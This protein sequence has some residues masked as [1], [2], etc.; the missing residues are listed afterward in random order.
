MIVDGTFPDFGASI[1]RE[2]L[3]MSDSK[4]IG[5]GFR[6]D[7]CGDSRSAVVGH[8]SRSLVNSVSRRNNETTTNWW[9]ATTWQLVPKSGVI[10]ITPLRWCEVGRR[11]V[12]AF[13]KPSQRARHRFYPFVDVES[14]VQNVRRR[15]PE[16]L[17]VFQNGVVAFLQS[18]SPYS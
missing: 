4:L 18:D 13:T 9:C 3:T 17:D 1:A 7:F 11:D 14:T 16:P 5:N 8:H 10:V 2:S 6:Q 12:F 15:H